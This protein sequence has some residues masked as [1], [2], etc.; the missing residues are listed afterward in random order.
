MTFVKP[1]AAP[2]AARWEPTRSMGTH[3]VHADD[4]EPPPGPIR[5]GRVARLAHWLCGIGSVVA[6]FDAPC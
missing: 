2:G 6:R 4:N 5:V 1:L 3:E